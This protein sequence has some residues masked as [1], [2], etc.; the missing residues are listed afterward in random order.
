MARLI[1]VL[2]LVLSMLPGSVAYADSR[3][4]AQSKPS[5]KPIW[6]CVGVGTGFGLGMLAGFYVL[7]DAIYA[8]RKIW[9][10]AVVSAGAGG[11]IGFLVDRERQRP[12]PQPSV[13]ARPQRF[14]ASSAPPLGTGEFRRWLERTDGLRDVHAPAFSGDR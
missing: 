8:E 14:D 10:T 3:D 4:P 6:T 5:F 13:L 7:D 12:S 1:P 2:T 9:T 11:I